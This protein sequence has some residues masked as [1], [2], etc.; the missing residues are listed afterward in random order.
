[1]STPPTGR[2]PRR[3]ENPLRGGLTG[4]ALV[5]LATL[6]VS[7]VAAVLTAVVLLVLG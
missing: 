7:A 6:F 1:M 5:A 2:R 4:I 3:D